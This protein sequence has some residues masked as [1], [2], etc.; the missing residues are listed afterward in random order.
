MSMKFQQ[1]LAFS[2]GALA[3][4]LGLMALI[5]WAT[6]RSLTLGPLSGRLRPELAVAFCSAGA[7]ILCSLGG[8]L[9]LLR[10]CAA[11]TAVASATVLVDLLHG[12]EI[13]AGSIVPLPPAEEGAGSTGLVAAA[14]LAV[15]GGLA[16]L[17]RWPNV[18]LML[19]ISSASVGFIFL[20]DRALEMTA[21]LSW[22][23]AVATSARSGV[24]LM[25]LGCGLFL[26]GSRR[27]AD[28]RPGVTPWMV[29]A[30]GVLASLLFWNILI[31]QERAG[32]GRL[33]EATAAGLRAE[34]SVALN[35]VIGEI[36]IL[37]ERSGRTAATEADAARWESRTQR[38][39][40]SHPSIVAI[41]WIAPDGRLLA[42]A[43]S[44][45]LATSVSM[46]Y[47]TAAE[48]ERLAADPSALVEAFPELPESL[49]ITALVEA[50]AGG[51]LESVVDMRQLVSGSVT[52]ADLANAIRI[53]VGDVV[54]FD[55][56]GTNLAADT[57]AAQRAVT[58]HLPAADDWNIAVG[59]S[60]NLVIS[61]LSP[62]PNI[63]LGAGI[64]ISLLLAAVLRGN[65]IQR[66]RAA[67]LERAVRVVETQTAELRGA[68]Q[69]LR[70]LNEDLENRVRARTEELSQA[71]AF[72]SE[73]NRLRK[74][75]Q[76][77][78]TR[79]NENL[80][81][82]DAFISHEL[83]QPLAAMRLWLDL[84]ESTAAG[85]LS[86]KQ[87]GYLAKSSGEIRRM[88]RLIEDELRLSKAS[89]G[90]PPTDPVA[91]PEV[92]AT[93]AEELGPRLA[94]AGGRLEIGE[95]PLVRASETQMLQLFTN[96][97]DNAIKYRRLDV[98]PLIR[99]ERVAAPATAADGETA[100]EIVVADN[101]QGFAAEPGENV[102]EMFS[103]R[104]S[105]DTTPGWGIGLAICKR[106]AE[107]HEGAIWAESEPGTGTRVH[108][109]LPLA[110]ADAESA[111]P[112][113]PSA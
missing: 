2:L 77:R 15:G 40:R 6:G 101:G 28:D 45:T 75:A 70:E 66:R 18:S 108:V 73:E 1:R 97:V 103:R 61:A 67:E 11:A 43:R 46:T 21:P 41:D 57:P 4:I 100:C 12:P 69:R 71:N 84:L 32:L 26:E 25:M 99:V 35:E 56:P 39:M 112:P 31:S 16:V 38:L 81:R 24:V 87:R 20:L 27:R 76:Q 111:S 3:A 105:D 68:Q 78:L 8:R 7:G 107:R 44:G 65:E 106:I 42:S 19:G 102:F 58:W 96:L 93:V 64:L 53:T 59:P 54:V 98:A 48:L 37:A 9:A 95:L 91:L 47:P 30:V 92:L 74:R 63:V 80:R 49:R 52:A 89:Y 82:F 34:L 22:P 5:A 29:G 17:T 36:E 51:V 79:V 109:V 23:D 104:A 10:L 86:E 72:L 110:E 14:L 50:G 88:T 83:R 60:Q 113:Q 13:A 85:S 94:E 90:E 33:L 55:N 62:L